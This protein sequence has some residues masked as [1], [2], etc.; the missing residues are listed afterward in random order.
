[1]NILLAVGVFLFPD[2]LCIKLEDVCMH[3]RQIRLID[4][5]ISGVYGDT[6]VRDA[7]W[8]VVGIALGAEVPHPWWPLGSFCSFL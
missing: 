1:M 4:R 6:K 5:F 7:I 3:I 8:P 2:C